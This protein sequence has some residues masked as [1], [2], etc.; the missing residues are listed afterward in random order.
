MKVFKG[1]TNFCLIALALIGCIFDI[2]LMVHFFTKTDVFTSSTST[3]ATSVTNP[4]TGE[5]IPPLTVSYFENYNNTGKEIVEF[6]I[7]A[8]SDHTKQ[9]L[10]CR[11]YQLVIDGDTTELYYC[12]SYNG[13]SWESAHKYDD[14]NDEGQYKAFYYIDIDDKVWAV[15]LDGSYTVPYTVKTKGYF[16]REMGNA[17]LNFVTF[18]WKS[19]N[20]V[21]YC[22]SEET[23]Y[24][25]VYYTYTD[26]LLQMKRILKSC[27]YGTGEYTMPLVD[28]GDFLHMYKV[29]EN[30]VVDDSPTGAGSLINSYFAI[31]VKFDKR[32]VTYAGQSMF[33]S[34]AG[35]SSYNISGVDYN[36]SYWK[37]AIVYNL[38]EQDFVSRYSSVDNGFYY[39]LS[40]QIINELKQ[41]DNLEIHISFDC[42]KFSNVKVLGFDYYALNGIEV[43]SL[44]ISSNNN[45]TFTLLVGS[46]QDTGIT[47]I[48]TNNVIINNLSGVAV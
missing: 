2:L 19:S 48:Q 18:N 22:N 33:G 41:Y 47:S 1:I 40:S 31:D 11:G 29:D 37:S 7:N 27:S 42:S 39:A 28:L 23:R 30:G 21:D 4:Q 26:L 32:G 45:Q 9:A 6:R 24:K 16:F 35:D 20:K 15:R 10:Y 34:V 46:L 5:K 43:E 13:M 17:V 36:V 8:Y 38:T 14:T 25:T 12:D 44:T 3:Y